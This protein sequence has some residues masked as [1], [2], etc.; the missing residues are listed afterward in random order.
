MTI[1]AK[2]P[3]RLRDAYQF[4]GF[5]P[6]A[7][8]KGVFGDPKARV[9]TLVR[10]EK[11]TVCGCCG[12]KQSGWYDRKTRRVRDL[13]CGDTRVWLELDVLRVACRVC[14]KVKTERLDFLADNPFYTKRF[15]WYVGRRCRQWSVRDVAREF[16]LDW[17]T[18]KALDKQYM[19]EQ[20]RVPG[21]SDPRR[22]ASTK[23]RSARVT[24]TASWSAI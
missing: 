14:D 24:L 1:H 13:S 3:R 16:R 20:L 12:H 23:S 6:Q 5:R 10:R 2:H 9:V 19:A 7:T 11:K 22:L 4:P 17:Q 18:V 15:A 8:V 21:C